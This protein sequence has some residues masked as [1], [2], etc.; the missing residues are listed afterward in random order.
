MCATLPLRLAS[1]DRAPDA[2]A[3]TCHV[4]NVE[5]ATAMHA[6]ACAAAA[7]PATASVAAAATAAA[8]TAGGGSG[9]GSGSGVYLVVV[10]K[11][12]VFQRLAEDRLWEQ[13][14]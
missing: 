3:E 9:S 7:G 4:C 5:R 1:G 13:R 6:C 11:D 2:A 12:A 10:E 8:A 14:E